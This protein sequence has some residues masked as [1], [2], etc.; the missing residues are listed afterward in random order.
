VLPASGEQRG[1]AHPRPAERA[2]DRTPQRAA[3]RTPERA[4][5]QRILRETPAPPPR[6]YGAP[7]GETAPRESIAL[8]APINSAPTTTMRR[9]DNTFGGRTIEAGDNSTTRTP[10]STSGYTP[11]AAVAGT[12]SSVTPAPAAAGSA[13]VSMPPAAAPAPAPPAP[14]DIVMAKIVKRVTPVLPG[15]I[16]RKAKGHVLVKFNITEAGRV[17]DVE[18][19]ESEP[20]GTFDDAALDA[21]R[22]WIYEPR[23]ENGV[24]VASTAKAKL[25]FDAAN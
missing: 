25:V 14:V 13:T 5:S 18:V 19:L 8:N 9:N 3:S 12:N 2:V 21:V 7:I 24:A 22:K 11:R 23:K 16:S 4:V 20:A 10:A 6:T 17:S 1:A 15:G